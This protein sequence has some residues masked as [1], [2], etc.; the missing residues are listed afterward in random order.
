LFTTQQN[1]EVSDQQHE[2]PIKANSYQNYFKDKVFIATKNKSENEMISISRLEY[3]KLIKDLSMQE[4]I[5]DGFQKENE[6]LTNKIKDREYEEKSRTAV[7]F[8][9]QEVLNKEINRLRNLHG[10]GGI[11]YSNPRIIRTT[12][13]DSK[14]LT[15]SI[16]N[17]GLAEVLRNE[18]DL[19]S[20]I[21]N[22]QERVIFAESG[23]GAREK[24]LKIELEKVIN[25]NR[26]LVT[27]MAI[28]SNDKDINKLR[29]EINFLSGELGKRDS[30]IDWYVSNQSLIDEIEQDKKSY[31]FLLQE[32]SQEMNRNGVISQQR[33][34]EIMTI[35]SLTCNLNKDRS[36]ISSSESS[37]ISPKFSGNKRSL[38]DIKR[39]KYVYFK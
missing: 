39:I 30:K 26:E 35:T 14:D 11:T 23:M 1:K 9:K 21:R 28:L 33:F 36:K 13:I 32:L 17:L 18:L 12:T 19:D 2:N 31:M 24:E 7:F 4:L 15:A 34:N 38:A 8:D 22:L 20:M 27:A 16:K 3:E 10:E 6:I 37:S 29:K 25:E 5:I